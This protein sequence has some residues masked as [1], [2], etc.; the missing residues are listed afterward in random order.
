MVTL[1]RRFNPIYTSFIQL[2][3]QIGTPFVVDAQYTLHIPD[4]SEGWRGK[5]AK[6]GGGCIIDMGYHL[7][8]MILWY[9]GQPN[10]MLADISVS[11]RP[12]RDYDAEDTA[13]IHFAYDSWPIPARCSS[14]GS[15]ARK[16]SRSG[17]GR[18]KGH[19]APRTRPGQA[20][21]Q[22][23]RR[24]R[25]PIAQQAWPSAA[26]CQVDYFC[27]VI[28][29]MRPNASGPIENLAHMS[30]ITACYKSARTY[31]Y[32][33]PKELLRMTSPLALLGG[34]SAVT[35]AAPALHL[36]AR[37]RPDGLSRRGPAHDRCLDLRLVRRHCRAGG[38]AVRVLRRQARGTN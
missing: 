9:F 26:A 8:D 17:P 6:A 38:C 34:P 1:Q 23:R 15:S 24:Y 21:D 14:P 4:P 7:I 5:T 30:F 13:L 36:A 33:N 3:D 20:P 16:A 2:A 37:G 29:G 18:V 32:V 31:A 27:R 25:G 35:E 22:R 10:R 12:D 11:A 28:D 19:R